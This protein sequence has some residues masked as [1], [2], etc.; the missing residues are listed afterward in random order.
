ML[1]APLSGFALQVAIVG[2]AVWERKENKVVAGRN[3]NNDS[4]DARLSAQQT[5]N[6]CAKRCG[7]Q[8]IGLC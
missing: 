1:N 7:E 3:K 5:N 6:Q 2:R 8:P 4:P